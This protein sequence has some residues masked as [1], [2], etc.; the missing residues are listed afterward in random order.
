MAAV[1]DEK[2]INAEFIGRSLAG[3]GALNF[4]KGAWFGGVLALSQSVGSAWLAVGGQAKAAGKAIDP[5]VLKGAIVNNMKTFVP[6]IV[7]SMVVFVMARDSFEQSSGYGSASAWLKATGLVALPTVG[8]VAAKRASPPA[9]LRFGLY[10]TVLLHV[11]DRVYKPGA[12][13]L[14]HMPLSRR[15]F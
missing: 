1:A 12:P 15:Q 6:G 14:E 5:T 11:Y 10:G 8:F 3:R 4:Y 13:F 9:A 2:K 7:G